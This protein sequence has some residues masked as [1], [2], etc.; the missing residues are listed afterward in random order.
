MEKIE[1]R[2]KYK[3]FLYFFFVFEGVV[4]VE[5]VPGTYGFLEEKNVLVAKGEQKK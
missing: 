4:K 1:I 5:L 3:I 2:E